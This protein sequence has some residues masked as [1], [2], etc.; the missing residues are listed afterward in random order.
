MRCRARPATSPPRWTSFSSE[1]VA[2]RVA[3][4]LK[5]DKAPD[6]VEAWKDSTDGKGDIIVWIGQ[7]LQK[8]L[9][10]TPSRDSSVIDV[11]VNWSDAKTAAVLAN[12]FAQAYIA[13]PSS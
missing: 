3:K 10:V 9:V 13:P 11:S 1:R 8:A 5:L 7:M 2:D 4:T 12:A 6:Y